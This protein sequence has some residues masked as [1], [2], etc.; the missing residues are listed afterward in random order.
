MADSVEQVVDWSE[1]NK[2]VV[3]PMSSRILNHAADLL[4][5]DKLEVVRG[6]LN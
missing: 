6:Y 1:A 4:R 5:K 3:L 2:D